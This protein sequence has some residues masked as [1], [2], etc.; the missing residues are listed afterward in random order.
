MKSEIE[1]CL[2]SRF[3]E[4][5]PYN[6]ITYETNDLLVDYRLLNHFGNLCAK[7]LNDSKSQ[8]ILEVI[9]YLYHSKDLFTQNAIE[10]EF[11]AVI[12]EKLGMEKMMDK[13]K[14]IPE[15]IQLIYIKVLLEIFKKPVTI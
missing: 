14:L 3:P 15:K 6:L 1:N 4:L 8:E 7:N 11:L 13:L 9:N 10:N 2:R 5:Y 12:A